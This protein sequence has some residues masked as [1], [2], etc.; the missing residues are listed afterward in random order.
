MHWYC[1]AQVSKIIMYE[2]GALKQPQATNHRVILCTEAAAKD[3]ATIAAK[4]PSEVKAR[5]KVV[6]IAR[7]RRR[8]CI[9]GSQVFA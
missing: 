1:Q 4:V 7:R 8:R 6:F 3:G 5:R 9:M 2:V